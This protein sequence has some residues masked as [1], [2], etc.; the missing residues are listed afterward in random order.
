MT[1][2]I[3]ERKRAIQPSLGPDL[4]FFFSH[5]PITS[6]SA[7]DTNP[8]PQPSAPPSESRTK[9]HHTM[10]RALVRPASTIYGQAAIKASPAATVARMPLGLT[11]ARTYASAG[12]AR[13]DVEKRV[14]DILAGFN[15]VDSNKVMSQ[16]IL[17]DDRNAELEEFYHGQQERKYLDKWSQNLQDWKIDPLR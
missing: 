8:P 13:S 12:L 4:P 14:L 11:F 6:D 10:F 1:K 2:T 16:V 15:K 5:K 9:L 3:K 17:W 7:F